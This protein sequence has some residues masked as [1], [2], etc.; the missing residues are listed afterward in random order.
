MEDTYKPFFEGLR[1]IVDRKPVDNL[2]GI[3]EECENQDVS[4]AAG[5]VQNGGR[6]GKSKIPTELSI[7]ALR[8]FGEAENDIL[9]GVSPEEA[10]KP[11]TS[12]FAKSGV[13]MD[14]LRTTVLYSLE[15]DVSRYFVRLA[16][17][18]G[19]KDYSQ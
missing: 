11:I 8:R 17:E 9:K 1:S 7:E 6:K 5:G 12:T 15:A 3:L 16:Q 4:E 18:N 14:Q 2:S 13:P 19:K 10:Y